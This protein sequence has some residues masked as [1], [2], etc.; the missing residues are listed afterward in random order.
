MISGK[1]S[2]SAYML[3]VCI[4]NP[5]SVTAGSVIDERLEAKRTM[6]LLL[7]PGDVFITGRKNLSNDLGKLAV[8]D[9][10]KLRGKRRFSVENW[11]AKYDEL[12]A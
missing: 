9:S 1:S 4:C 8:D 11:E 10:L 5:D 3:R 7:Y 12:T 6:L 2:C